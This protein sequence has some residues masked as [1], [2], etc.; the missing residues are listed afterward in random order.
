[1]QATLK[2]NFGTQNLFAMFQV[3]PS[4]QLRGTQTG[5]DVFKCD[6]SRRDHSA[7]VIGSQ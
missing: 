1:M 2:N 5:A 7:P 6:V 4:P 3:T